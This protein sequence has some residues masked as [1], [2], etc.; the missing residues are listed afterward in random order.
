MALGTPP[1]G[2]KI[3]DATKT[4]DRSTAARIRLS[5]AWLWV[6]FLP[7]TLFAQGRDDSADKTLSPYFFVHSDDPGVDKLPLKAT[8]VQVSIAGV[9]ADVKVTQRYRNDG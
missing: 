8:D 7:A 2:E 9:I 3:M 5:M 6:L 1:C 4:C